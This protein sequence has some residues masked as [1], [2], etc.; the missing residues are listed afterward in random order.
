[1]PKVKSEKGSSTEK[2]PLNWL[3]TIG[4]VG[5]LML[6]ATGATLAIWEDLAKK[7]ET[8]KVDAA[9]VNVR[10]MQQGAVA[11]ESTPTNPDLPAASTSGD[12]SSVTTQS[13][14][15]K[16]LPGGPYPL[17]VTRKQTPRRFGAKSDE[18]DRRFE[19]HL[20]LVAHKSSSA[21]HSKKEWPKAFTMY[22]Q[23]HQ[24]L[25]RKILRRSEAA[26]ATTRE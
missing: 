19:G 5:L 18:R 1:L 15:I 26:S 17:S 24:D 14:A 12:P 8:H 13:L 20:S 16:S 9:E 7:S 10:N 25:L 21:P 2:P 4:G 23:A 3:A 11:V 6:I 22:L